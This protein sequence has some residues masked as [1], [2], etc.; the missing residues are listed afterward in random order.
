[1][2]RW[3]PLNKGCHLHGLMQI[4]TNLQSPP[5]LPPAPPAV[6]PVTTSN[7]GEEFIIENPLRSSPPSPNL[8]SFT[9]MCEMS[10]P[11]DPVLL[12]IWHPQVRPLQEPMLQEESPIPWP[13]NQAALSPEPDPQ[14]ATGIEKTDLVFPLVASVS[15]TA[16]NDPP[17]SPTLRPA[18]ND[19]STSTCTVPSG[20]SWVT[21]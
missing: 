13:W 2:A 15:T 4:P 9:S 11:I 18:F 8:L 16:L 6:P 14:A 7:I 19:L 12:A 5:Q 10:I 17:L 3:V 20:Y 1:M 21:S